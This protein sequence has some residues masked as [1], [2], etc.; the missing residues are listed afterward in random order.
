MKYIIDELHENI[1]KIL[2]HVYWN[3]LPILDEVR[4]QGNGNPV[5]TVAQ[6]EINCK[7]PL[8]AYCLLR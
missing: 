6:L 3:L 4:L 5:L 8:L 2:F 7:F 1:W